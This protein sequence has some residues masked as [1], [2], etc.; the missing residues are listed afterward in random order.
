MVGASY[1]RLI[2]E[3][4]RQIL[5]ATY[6]I[7]PG[8]YSL[9]PAIYFE[10]SFGLNLLPKKRSANY[11][12]YRDET[13]ISRFGIAN[14][15]FVIRDCHFGFWDLSFRFLYTKQW[16]WGL[17]FYVSWFGMRIREWCFGFRIGVELFNVGSDRYASLRFRDFRMWS[18]KSG[19][20]ILVLCFW[21]RSRIPTGDNIT[22]LEM[23]SIGLFW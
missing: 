16:Y 17:K 19:I 4:L 11:M 8:T 20:K 23:L 10:K 22:W 18:S 6:A 2:A 15:D 5:P 21:S 3:V 1:G 7:N 12:D 9:G 14:R 13:W